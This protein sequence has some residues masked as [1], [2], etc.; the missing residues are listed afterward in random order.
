MAAVGMTVHTTCHLSTHRGAP[1][2]PQQLVTRSVCSKWGCGQ[3]GLGTRLPLR[4][5]I[6]EASHV[7]AVAAVE[8]PAPADT[9]L[10]M[11]AS[12]TSPLP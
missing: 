1:A 12:R 2:C 11:P 10:G 9:L 8:A 6:R 3:Q 4:S 7:C 5:L